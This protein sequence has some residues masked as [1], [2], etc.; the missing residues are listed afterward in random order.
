MTAVFEKATLA[1]ALYTIAMSDSLTGA[2]NTSSGGNRNLRQ[3]MVGEM[4]K[5]HFSI[6]TNAGPHL[7]ERP[8]RLGL[9]EWRNAELCLAGKVIGY[10]R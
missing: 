1:P 10:E 3:R 4:D 8:K 6:S 7:S 2:R 9:G 5:A